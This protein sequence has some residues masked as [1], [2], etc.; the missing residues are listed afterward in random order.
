[1]GQ[2][3]VGTIGIGVIGVGVAFYYR[4]C[5]V[6]FR[7]CLQIGTLNPKLQR[8]VIAI[9]RVGFLARGSILVLIGGYVIQAAYEFDADKVRSSEETLETIKLQPYG[10]GLLILVAFGL[11][12]YGVHMGLQ[13]WYRQVNLPDLKTKLKE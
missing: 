10:P 4:S 8:M 12:A 6:G 11:I 7:K 5:R 1:M 9:G 2:G 13:A 3:L